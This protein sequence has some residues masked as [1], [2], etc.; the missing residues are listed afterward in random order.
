MKTTDELLGRLAHHVREL[1]REN[2]SLTDAQ[3]A[4]GARLRLKAEMA[5]R[6]QQPGER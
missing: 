4:K 1:L 3:V 2:P 6:A 5:E